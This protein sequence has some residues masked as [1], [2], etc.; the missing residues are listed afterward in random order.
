MCAP[1][2][3]LFFPWD[4]PWP[5][6]THPPNSS[7]PT[8]PFARIGIILRHLRTAQGLSRPELAQRAGVEAALIRTIEESQET[9][10]VNLSD[11]DAVLGDFGIQLRDLSAADWKLRSDM[12]LDAQGREIV[13]F[14]EDR[15]AEL[16]DIEGRE[17]ELLVL[18]IER[19]QARVTTLEDQL[20]QR[21][22]AS[23]RSLQK[24]SIKLLER[25]MEA[26]GMTQEDMRRL[27]DNLVAQAQ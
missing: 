16:E 21:D 8:S 7:L 26:S 5:V 3:F 27:V 18:T 20:K 12:R 10:D 9:P 24:E 6:V 25:A 13:E 14:D 2:P 17:M 23:M 19:L 4:F 1:S 11:L 22:S 15:E